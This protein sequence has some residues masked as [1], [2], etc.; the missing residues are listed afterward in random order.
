MF[1]A[2]QLDQDETEELFQHKPCAGE[3]EIFHS[4][5]TGPNF[6]DIIVQGPG[7]S[8]KVRNLKN[9]QLKAGDITEVA[10]DVNGNQDFNWVRYEVF[11]AEFAP[12][13]GH[14]CADLPE[15]HVLTDHV[16]H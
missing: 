13:G 16:H 3:H 5:N 15:E 8:S 10:R 1:D 6:V 2:E 7:E 4:E 12:E 9:Y 11:E 14:N